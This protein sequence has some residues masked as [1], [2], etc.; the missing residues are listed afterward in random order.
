MQFEKF[1]HE[2]RP[3]VTGHSSSTIRLRIEVND[4]IE[5]RA[6]LPFG[7]LRVF[8]DWLVREFA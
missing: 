4:F 2:L 6:N 3:A 5:R 8:I 1:S 7:T